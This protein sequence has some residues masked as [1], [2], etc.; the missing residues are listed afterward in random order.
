MYLRI[1]LVVLCLG[2]YSPAFAG[3]STV[4]LEDVRTANATVVAATLHAPQEVELPNEQDPKQPERGFKFKLKITDV[5]RRGKLAD[6]VREIDVPFSSRSYG[7]N[8]E[9]EASPKDGMEVLAYFA[10]D[11]EGKL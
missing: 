3:R 1:L 11:K 8:W 4:L 10:P 7:G 5:V 2:C 6:D 9:F